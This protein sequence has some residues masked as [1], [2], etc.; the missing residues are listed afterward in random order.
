[1]ETKGKCPTCGTPVSVEEYPSNVAFLVDGKVVHDCP[2]CGTTLIY[3]E[4]VG[5]EIHVEPP[6]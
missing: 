3:A 2:K 5:L 6:Q 1:M 4:V